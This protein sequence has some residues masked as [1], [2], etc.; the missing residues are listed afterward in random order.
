MAEITNGISRDVD[1]GYDE[2][3]FMA[4]AALRDDSDY[5]QWFTNGIEWIIYLDDTDKGGLSCFQYFAM[6]RDINLENFHKATA[7]EI[8]THFKQKE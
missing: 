8:I 2:N 5:M 3:L 4:L 7:G 1:C 6:P